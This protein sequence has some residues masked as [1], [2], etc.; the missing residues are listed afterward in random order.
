MAVI[1]GVR[2]R[3]VLP[4]LAAAVV[5]AV[6]AGCGADD[7]IGSVPGAQPLAASSA[8]SSA[9]AEE[10]CSDLVA[11]NLTEPDV[12]ADADAATADKIAQ[13]WFDEELLPLLD[14]VVSGAP[15][16]AA[17][18]TATIGKIIKEGGLEALDDPAFLPAEAAVN[19]AAVPACGAQKI[20]ITA[21]DYAFHGAPD[22]LPTGLAV[23]RFIGG[24]GELHE[25]MLLR[26]LPG[27]TQS[28]DELLALPEEESAKLTEFVG[29]LFVTPDQTDTAVVDL[30]PG[31]YL[32]VSTVPIGLTPQ[33]AESGVPP[34][35][36][37]QFTRGMKHEFTVT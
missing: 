26:K 20:T 29:G 3:L 7:G 9:L 4:A 8:S 19:E 35:G 12:P 21:A 17:N 33:A 24:G 25:L 15:P 13:R 22:S 6:L 34:T 2:G 11:I 32:M 5:G 18:A 14:N 27:T 37:P 28:F 16:A 1:G 10:W 23:I 31:N 30:P 36:E